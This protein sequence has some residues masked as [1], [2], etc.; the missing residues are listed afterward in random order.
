MKVGDIILTIKEKVKAACEHSGMSLTELGKRM[1]MSQ[2]NISKRLKV[3]KF[4]QE[5]LQQMAKILDC[6]Y[7]CS[8]EFSDG[9]KIE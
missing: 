6:K 8:F 1:G 5:E 2:A 9:T 4:T 3:G 7:T